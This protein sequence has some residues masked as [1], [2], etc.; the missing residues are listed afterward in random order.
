MEVDV[1]RV[2]KYIK[3]NNV[4]FSEHALF[5]FL[6]DPSIDPRQRL[7]IAPCMAF[8]AM[9]FRDLNKYVYR[10]VIDN[11]IFQEIVNEHTLEDE[12]HS[13]W[14]IADYR[15]LDIDQ[16]LTF[17]DSLCFLWGRETIG[18]RRA[19]YDFSALLRYA[20]PLFRYVVLESLEGHGHVL[21]TATSKAAEE[22][23]AKTGRE[24]IFFG[25]HHLSVET[26]HAMGEKV[27]LLQAK[28]D[29]Y[30]LTDEQYEKALTLVDQTYEIFTRYNDDLYNYITTH[31]IDDRLISKL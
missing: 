29:R 15:R 25:T 28:I 14:F 21:F 5:S 4:K 17:T 24:Y 3:N 9:G 8:F 23:S 31:R 1:E 13:A 20:P 30:Q 6:S 18:V 22:L 11:D 10:E 27:A 16:K 2:N 12:R 19:I 26:G 7:L